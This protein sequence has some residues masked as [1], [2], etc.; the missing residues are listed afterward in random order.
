MDVDGFLFDLNGV[1]YE[2]GNIIF[3]ANETIDWVK[4]NSIPFKFISN[5]STLSRKL[6]SCPLDI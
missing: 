4:K 5:N 6:S 2:D 1:F 3:G